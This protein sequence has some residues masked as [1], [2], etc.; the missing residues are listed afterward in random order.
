MSGIEGWGIGQVGLGSITVAHRQGYHLYGQPVG[1]GYDPQ[2][3][4]RARFAEQEPGATVYDSLEDLLGD[5][6]VAV[7]DVATPHHRETRLPVVQQIADA[8]IPMLIQKPLA[9]TYAEAVEMV[10]AIERNGVVGMVNQNMCF[11][12]GSLRLVDALMRDEVVG[13]PDFAQ[14]TVQYVFDLPDHPW[15]GK[16]D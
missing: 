12:P 11:T 16:D 9:Y 13:R 15:F 2:A 3:E 6:R 10:D 7:V 14:V 8:G 4:A 5:P 1:A